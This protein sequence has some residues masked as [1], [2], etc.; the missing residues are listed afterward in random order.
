[1]SFDLPHLLLI[2]SLYLLILFLCAWACEN[3]KIPKNILQHPAVYIFSLGIFASSWAYYGSIGI[4]NDDGYVFLAFYFGLCGAF[5]LAPVLLKPLL[6]ITTNYQL[7][8]LADLMAFRFRSQIAGTISALLLLIISLPLLALQ[9]RA[10]SGSIHILSKDAA[11]EQLA[12]IFCALITLFT[13]L[14]GTRQIAQRKHHTGLVFAIAFES[15]LKLIIM[16]ILGATA[17]LQVFDGPAGLNL[18]LEQNPE[19]IVG[20]NSKLDDG[21][22]RTTLL[23]FFASA[24]VMPHMFHM[25]FAENHRQDFLNKASWGLPLFLLVLSFSTPLILWA[26]IKLGSQLPPEYFPLGIGIALNQPW[27]TLTAYIGGLSAATGLI[28]VTLLALSSMLMNHLV[29][30]YSRHFGKATQGISFYHWLSLIK[31]TLIISLILTAYGF[32][33]M[34]GQN[35]DLYNLGI[36]A[37]V[38]ALQLL[39]ATLATLYWSR[40]NHYGFI[41]GVASGATIWFLTLMLPLSMGLGVFPIGVLYPEHLSPDSWHIAAASSLAVNIIVMVM[42][43]KLT[44]MSDEETSAAKACMIA[45]AGYQEMKIPKAGSAR[46]FLEALSIPLGEKVARFEVARALNELNMR[47]GEN[48]PHALRQLRDKIETNLSGLM[49]PTIAHDIV[50]KHLPLDKE[51]RYSSQDIHI[52]ESKLE[53]YR[54]RLTGLA[55]ELDNLRR[56]HQETLHNL[57]MAVCSISP[58]STGKN[59]IILWNQAM[60]Q[61]TGVQPDRA[62]G[63]TLKALPSPWNQLLENFFLSEQNH[64]NKHNIEIDEMSRYFGLHKASVEITL[65]GRH[66]QVMLLEDQTET[67]ILEE[68]LFHNERL[69]SIGQLAAGVAHE[70]GNPITGIDC[71]AQELNSLSDDPDVYHSALLIRQ[72]TERVTRI[73]RSLMTYAHSGRMASSVELLTETVSLHDCVQEAITLLSLNHKNRNIHFV[74]H[75]NTSHQVPGNIQQ[76]QQV[77]LNLLKNASEACDYEGEIVISSHISPEFITV[78][79]DDTGQGIPK[80]IQ[81]KL[82]EPFF[83]TKGAGKGTGLG[84]AL[85]W[86]IIK[87]HDGTIRVK[88]PLNPLTEKGTRFII[89]LPRH[90]LAAASQHKLPDQI[91][92]GETV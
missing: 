13:L 71:L 53:T 42:V 83:T 22:W 56:Y 15:L 6:R 2:T 1:M 76:L 46:E 80:S 52:V 65:S 12:I 19:V 51:N 62:V 44:S 55:E 28:I 34:M 63:V 89:S 40:A 91:F 59:E 45:P 39:P 49:G 48:R 75:C 85:C 70:I 88:S 4:A 73:V 90:N 10:V 81:E 58:T 77:F 68:Q 78:H 35:V 30:P 26:G 47:R 36:V 32:Y 18:W 14:F 72:Q 64:W 11:P 33:R 67:Q 20:M 57:P 3:N 74:N 5:L 87:D 61:M 7:S 86:N 29:L 43:S 60:T 23:M 25:I 27:L 50:Q 38:G 84:L 31:R 82:F 16:V 69:A 24:I 9:I 8:S 37:Y 21:P 17:V 79:V 41:A 66:Q 54:T 92:Q